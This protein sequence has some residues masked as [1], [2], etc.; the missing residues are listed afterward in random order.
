MFL[1]YHLIHFL[2]QILSE[3]NFHWKLEEK[4]KIKNKSV[5]F[6]VWKFNFSFLFYSLLELLY[7]QSY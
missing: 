5:E 4:I 3:V 1:I 2:G 6:K 7:F